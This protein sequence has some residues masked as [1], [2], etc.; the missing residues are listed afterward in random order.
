MSN[1]FIS[2][3]TWVSA[4]FRDGLE[5]FLQL[6]TSHGLIPRTLGA[7]DYATRTPLDEVISLMKQCSGTIILGFPQIGIK[8]G[9]LKG[10]SIPQGND[11]PFLLATEWNHI[12]AALA[13][14][15]GLPL[16]VIH[17]KGVRRGIFDR[18]TISNFIYEQDLTDASW[19]LH[20]EISGAFTKWKSE[21]QQSK[22]G[23]LPGNSELV[24]TMFQAH[25]VLWN[26]IGASIEEIAYCPT[27][28][29]AMSVFPPG[30]NEMIACSKCNFI[31]PFRP[32]EIKDKARTAS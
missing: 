3:P 12:E 28:K 24:P 13:H 16:L 29:L 27:C 20:R 4:E 9:T 22:K 5:C 21:L 17:H 25:G 26:R 10:K 7:S 2:R 6:L 8:K 23:T 31:A 1:V 14:A 30:S 32:N 11:T 15:S 19:P 18:G